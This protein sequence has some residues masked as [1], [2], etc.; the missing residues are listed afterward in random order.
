MT[1]VCIAGAGVI[2]SLLAG[3]LAQVAEVSVLTR[4]SEHARALEP[5]SVVGHQQLAAALLTAKRYDEAARALMAGSL[6]TSSPRGVSVPRQ[7]V[8][9]TAV[10]C[11]SLVTA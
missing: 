5:A 1:R 10:F 9:N 3:H 2:G 4:R 8:S 11:W 7:D 6:L